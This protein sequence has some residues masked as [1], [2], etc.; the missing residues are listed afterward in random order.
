M[1]ILRGAPALSSFR[2]NKLFV[3]CKKLVPSLGQIYAEYVHFADLSKDLSEQE[4]ITLKKLLTYGSIKEVKETKG[5]FVLVVPRPG[6]IS[7]WS[8][9]ATDIARN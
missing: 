4:L 1:Q 7:P 6:T 3:E 2:I 5:A 8:S 9:K